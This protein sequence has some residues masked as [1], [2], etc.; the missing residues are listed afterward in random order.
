MSE[1]ILV[2]DLLKLAGFAPC[3]TLLCLMDP[4]YQRCRSSLLGS[5]DYSWLI[6]WCCTSFSWDT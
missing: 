5:S 2:S 3:E 1:V 6:S 4:C